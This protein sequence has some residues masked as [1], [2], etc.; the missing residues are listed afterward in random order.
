MSVTKIRINQTQIDFKDSVVAATVANIADL[1]AGAP[2]TV[3]GVSLAVQDRVLVKDQ[4]TQ[5]QNGIYRV[6]TVGTG[7][8]GVWERVE[9]FFTGDIIERGCVVFVQ[10]GGT[11]NALKGFQISSAGTA[12][13]HVVG[14]D[15]IAFTS[16]ADANE[17]VTLAQHVYNEVMTGTIDGSNLIF[18]TATAFATG[19]LRVYLNGVRQILGDDYTVTGVD[20]ITFTFAPKGAPGNPDIV[21]CDYLTS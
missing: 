8:N 21:T 14:T 9:D 20:E 17:G 12:G 2:D 16:L 1:A 15:S 13:A 6:L 5:S 19:K 11:A 18:T 10:A 4:T 3:D 7:A